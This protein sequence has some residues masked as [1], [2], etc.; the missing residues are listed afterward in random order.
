MPLRVV[1]SSARQQVGIVDMSFVAKAVRYATRTRSSQDLLTNFAGAARIPASLVPSAAGLSESLTVSELWS[2]RFFAIRSRDASGNW[3][4]VSD[5]AI[6]Q[7]V[8]P[9]EQKAGATLTIGRN[10][11]SPPLAFFWQVPASEGSPKSTIRVTT[12]RAASPERSCWTR[13]RGNDSS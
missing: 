9:I 3:S 6:R 5:P 12:S 4:P 1:W 11:C 2:G 7:S 8:D 10:P 13:R